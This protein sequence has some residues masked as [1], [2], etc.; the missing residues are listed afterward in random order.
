[1]F[2]SKCLLWGDHSPRNGTVDMSQAISTEF[3]RRIPKTDLHVHL[4][5]SLRLSTL[6]EL[7]KKHKVKLPAYTEDG[8]RRLVFKDHYAHLPDYLKGF[9]YTHAVMQNTENLER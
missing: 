7:A 3:I 2:W 1:M 8:M 6:I 4:G 9:S 5:G